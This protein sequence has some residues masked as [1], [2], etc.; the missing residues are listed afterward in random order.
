MYIFNDWT[1]VLIPH[2]HNERHYG[3]I[4]AATD[5]SGELEWSKHKRLMVDLDGSASA[6]VSIRSV[7]CFDRIGSKEDINDWERKWGCILNNPDKANYKF[8]C[9]EISGNPC[10]WLNKG[11][12]IWGAQDMRGAFLAYVKQ[13]L[14]TLGVELSLW[15]RGQL[16]AC[17]VMPMRMDITSNMRVE[18]KPDVKRLLNAIQQQAD[19]R[20]QGRSAVGTTAYFGKDSKVKSLVF[21]DKE[22]EFLRH[23]TKNKDKTGIVAQNLSNIWDETRGLIRYELKLKSQWFRARHIN[24]LNAFFAYM[25]DNSIM[26]DELDKLSLGQMDLSDDEI[27]QQEAAL[28]KAL[29]GQ[30]IRNRVIDSFVKWKQ[31]L[32]VKDTIQKDTFYKH[33]KIIEEHTQINIK[34]QRVLEGKGK[35]VPLITYIR[36]SFSSPG[37]EYSDL[38][39]T[40]PSSTLKQG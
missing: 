40:P 17:L 3:G 23:A 25:E 27:N 30:R 31:G 12:N 37:K 32:N 11:H 7:N 5:E 35:V 21:Y 34:N 14:A 39:Y 18:S 28:M 9:L 22:T 6:R 26:E 24:T 16:K 1:T 8:D 20:Y 2:N 33:R 29:E 38:I 36:A 19:S 4:V 13:V 15:E 10:K